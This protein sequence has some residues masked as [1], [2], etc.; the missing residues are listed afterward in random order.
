MPKRSRKYEIGL[1]ERLKDSRYAIEYLN[2]AAD[3]SDE[4][5]LLALRDVAEARKGFS[6]LSAEAHVNRENL[7]RMLSKAGNPRYYSFRAVLK[8][9][10]L[11]L[12]LAEV[13]RTSSEPPIKIAKQT[14]SRQAYE[15]SGTRQS[16]TVRQLAFAF[17]VGVAVGIVA[18]NPQ[19]AAMATGGTQTLPTANTV[20]QSATW[21]LQDPAIPALSLPGGVSQTPGVNL[22][23][24]VASQYAEQALVQGRREA[25]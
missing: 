23:F 3:D 19:V 12:F 7:Y 8:A 13:R 17:G 4:A 24:L 22:A 25:L 11:R 2:V 1:A 10:G 5:L 16:G 20:P 18:S 21:K 15:Q 6:R 14:R 9:L